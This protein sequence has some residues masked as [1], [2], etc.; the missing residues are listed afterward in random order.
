MASLSR[1]AFSASILVV[2]L[3]LIA[4]SD[5]GGGTS[6]GTP[7]TTPPAVTSVTPVD[8][9]HI[10]VGFNE[11]LGRVSAEDEDNYVIIEQTVVL[12][13][14]AQDWPESPGDTLQVLAASLNSDLRTVS[15]TTGAMGVVP[16]NMSVVGV[17]DASGNAVTNAPVASFTGTAD[18]D[19]T[20]PEIVYRSP[21]PNAT[22]AG[23]GQPLVVQF[24]EP[25]QYNSVNSSLAWVSD[26]GQGVGTQATTDDL[27]RFTFSP[28]DPLENGVL[29]WVTFSF[30][31]DFAGNTMPVTTWSYT[32]TSVVDATPPTLVSSV[33]ANHATNVNVNTNLSLTFSE[34]INQGMI[35]I[36]LL[37]DPGEGEVTWSN[38][39][40]TLT[41]DPVLP[42][43]DDQQYNL[44]IFPGG[45]LD[46]A[47]NGIVLPV[48]IVFTTGNALATGSF[49]GTLT[50]DPGSNYADDP[51]GALVVA[52]DGF[53]FG[54]GDFNI[55]GT[56]IVAGNNTYNIA[57]LPNGVYYPISVMN[58]NGDGEFDPSNGDAI[59]AFG[60]DLAQ[61]DFEPDS[62]TIT[63]GAH[64]GNV[65][66]PLFDPSAITGTV[67]YSG[68][69]SVGEYQIGVGVF[70]VVGFDPTLPPAYG[71]FIYWPYETAWSFNT[72]DDGLADG[73]YYLGAFLDLNGNFAYDP[74]TEPAG[75]YGGL[76]TP[77]AVTIANGRDVLD[78][79]ITMQDPVTSLR[80]TAKVAW[81]APAQRAPW[82]TRLSELVRQAGVATPNH[83]G[84]TAKAGSI[85]GGRR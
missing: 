14:R 31:E 34:A 17:A 63:G 73:S 24:S 60:A 81:P 37:P 79:E 20:G 42:L 35:L 12:T 3:A 1:S 58:T 83:R 8:Q 75:L 26:G 25:V 4:C 38:N 62:V 82:L 53:P 13:P 72:L 21:A 40:K 15:L 70:E 47:G 43:L 80:S 69:F 45:V 22:G 27:V 44:T 61:G 19:V 32:T 7:D 23:I 68:Q 50:G 64:V 28:N 85:G 66:F 2:M 84:E 36:Q 57:N 67:A 30:V 78:I 76:Q 65:N 10:D 9:Y 46:L 16:Y 54:G 77:T 48:T 33:P 74:A 59:G 39:G 49:G 56:G 71:A 29:Y 18:P 41:F 51:T 52:P 6:G 5:D 11:N 55:L